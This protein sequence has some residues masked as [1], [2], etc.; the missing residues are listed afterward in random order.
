MTRNIKKPYFRIIS[1]CNF[2]LRI[3]TLANMPFHVGLAG[4]NPNFTHQDVFEGLHRASFDTKNPRMHGGRLCGQINPPMSMDIGPILTSGRTLKTHGDHFSGRG[5]TPNR[6]G[7]IT[8]QHHVIAKD[9]R[10]FE[11]GQCGEK[12]W[13]HSSIV[14]FFPERWGGVQA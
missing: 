6:N 13:N 5:G 9:G 4:A 3:G 10:K 12:E 1:L 2:F 7:L 11:S 14:P 8:L